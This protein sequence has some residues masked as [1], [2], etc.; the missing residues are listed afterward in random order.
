[1]PHRQVSYRTDEVPP[2]TEFYRSSRA[3]RRLSMS[4]VAAL[5]MALAGTPAAAQ[6]VALVYGEPITSMDVEQRSKLVQASTKKA[7]TR[8]E[9]LDELINEKLKIREGKRFGL[10]A[11]ATEVDNAFAN[12]AGRMR[13]STQQFE[14]ALGQAGIK[15][16]TLKTR[17]RAEIVWTQLV[18]GRYQSTLQIGE[19]DVLAAVETK[20]SN[21]K[22]AVGF[23]YV[24]R[25]I[26]FIVS[27]GSAEGNREAKRREAD[28]FRARFASCEDGIKAAR[29][30]RD[31]AVRNEVTRN[32]SDLAPALREILEKTPI[33]RLT[34]PEATKTGIEMF[35]VCSKKQTTVD[36]PVKKAAKEELFAERYE[37]KS[38]QYLQEMRKSAMIEYR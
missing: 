28:A 21:D 34:P 15:A 29:G 25:P 37:A 2:M 7:P 30:L 1:M 5:L 24:L 8:Q 10:E 22:E 6:V 11:S 14:S 12:M 23:D 19:R 17:L 26:V 38:K 4:I 3:G 9:V 32:T 31:V 13:L 35:A 36:T 33:G 16:D 20:K 27:Q 18:R